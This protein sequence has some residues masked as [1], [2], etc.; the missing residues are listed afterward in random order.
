LR[1]VVVL[2]IL[3][4]ALGLSQTPPNIV[5]VGLALA[6]TFFVMR[7]VIDNVNT[8][9]LQPYL[10]GKLEFKAAVNKAE[11]PLRKFMT[12]QTRKR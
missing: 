7:P 8:Q 2:A 3:R 4:Q 9:A 10:A 5:L 12:A 1:I 6:L 11:K